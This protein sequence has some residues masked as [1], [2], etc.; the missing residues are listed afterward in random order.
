LLNLTGIAKGTLSWTGKARGKRKTTVM[1]KTTVKATGKRKKKPTKTTI[2][3]TGK[4]M[5]KT[6]RKKTLTS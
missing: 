5:R 4:R 1:P 3:P 2:Q 6:K